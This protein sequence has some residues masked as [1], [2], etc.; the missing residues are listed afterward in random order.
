MRVVE[1]PIVT[2]H[3]GI[4]GSECRRLLLNAC[5]FVNVTV[6]THVRDMVGRL[7]A[8]AKQC[9]SDEINVGMVVTGHHHVILAFV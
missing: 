1:F 3:V 5:A 6:I 2:R 8:A 4:S 9:D 7:R